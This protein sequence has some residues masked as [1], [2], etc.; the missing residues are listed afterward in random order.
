MENLVISSTCQINGLKDIYSKYL[1]LQNGFFVEVGAYD[2][3]TWSNTSG[4][5]D[6]GWSGIYIEPIPIYMNECKKR[7]NNNNIIFEECA[8]SNSQT[9]AEIKIVGGLSTLSALAHLANKAFFTSNHF[10]KE[11]SIIVPCY[12]LDDILRKNNVSK[13]FELLVV[14]VEGYETQV[15]DSF[16]IEFYKPKMIICEL[17]DNH[18]ITENFNILRKE[19]VELR[20]KIISYGYKEIHS[21]PINTI[22]VL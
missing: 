20:K 3:G 22:F 8:I 10:E 21:D 2:G 5:A 11:H 7:H 14:D 16:S 1:N 18:P 4:L 12:K 19:C 6:I 17:M 9:T 13:N 15:F